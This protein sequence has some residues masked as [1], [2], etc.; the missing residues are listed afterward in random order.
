[1]CGRFTRLRQ[2]GM[3]C[4]S[5]GQRGSHAHRVQPGG[6]LGYGS[7]PTAGSS[8]RRGACWSAL[9]KGV[10]T[11][12]GRPAAVSMASGSASSR[13]GC[14]RRRRPSRSSAAE[15]AWSRRW[16]KG[17]T[18][19]VARTVAAPVSWASLGTTSSGRPVLHEQAAA[20]RTQRGIELRQ[21]AQQEPRPSRRG[22]RTGHESL[23]EHE[24]R[25]HPACAGRRHAERRMVGDPQVA[26][27][28][29]RWRCPPTPPW[30]SS[31]RVRVLVV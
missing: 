8:G 20:A 22:R 12:Y 10:K 18:S 25:D 6:R 3:R 31:R 9:Q 5:T 13:P 16:L 19:R 11:L 1:M 15:T 17:V 23:V 21:R 24:E 29:R 2:P 27:G 7:A 28:T 30:C 14:S 26:L 4:L